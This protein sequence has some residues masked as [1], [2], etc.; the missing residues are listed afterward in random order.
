M[1][2]DRTVHIC[3]ANSIIL[4][5]S[6]IYSTE[7]RY[8]FNMATS[9]ARVWPC[10]AFCAQCCTRE[11]PVCFDHDIHTIT[12]LGNRYCFLSRAI[13]LFMKW[14]IHDMNFNHAWLIHYTQCHG[15]AQ[16]MLSSVQHHHGHSSEGEE[17]HVTFSLNQWE[18]TV[19]WHPFLLW[20]FEKTWDVYTSD[21]HKQVGYS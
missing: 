12:S 14:I 1:D 15:E 8:N 7:K 4:Y 16:A 3:H 10:I 9:S 11:H 2:F 21:H 20:S 5:S 19:I 6:L 13:R 18:G 17:I